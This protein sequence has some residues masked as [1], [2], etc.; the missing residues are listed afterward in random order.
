VGQLRTLAQKAV[1]SLES[2]GVEVFVPRVPCVRSHSAVPLS[3]QSPFSIKAKVP[4]QLHGMARRAAFVVLVALVLAAPVYAWRSPSPAEH[5]AIVAAIRKNLA[6]SGVRSVQRVRV[7]TVDR[8][9][10]TAVTYP[11]DKAGRVLSRDAWLLRRGVHI[12]RVVF[13]GSDMP[14]CNIASAPVRRDLL[15]Y[16]TC[17]S[18]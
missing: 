18:R 16:A 17:F 13:V 2:N 3:A 1:D 7:S 8:R 9:F 6:A 15:G 11:R 5:R 4:T 14:P 12:W 10:A